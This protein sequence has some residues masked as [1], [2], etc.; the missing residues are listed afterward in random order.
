MQPIFMVILI[1]MAGGIFVALQASLAGIISERLGLIEK[2]FFCIWGWVC[3]LPG[4]IASCWY[5]QH[6]ELADNSLVSYSWLARWG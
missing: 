3:I 2:C 1:G 6:K 4:L 5:W